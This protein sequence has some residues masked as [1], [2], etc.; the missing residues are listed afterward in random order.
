MKKGHKPTFVGHHTDEAKARIAKASSK[1][2]L[3]DDAKL[4]ISIKN[5][6]HWAEKREN[7]AV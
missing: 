2:R 7:N 4:R 3:S 5:K 1:R 6:A